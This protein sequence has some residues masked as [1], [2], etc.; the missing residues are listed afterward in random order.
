MKKYLKIG[1]LLSERGVRVAIYLSCVFT[2]GG[3]LITFNS[4][5]VGALRFLCQVYHQFECVS[6]NFSRSKSIDMGDVRFVEGYP[7]TFA[8]KEIRGEGPGKIF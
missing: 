7:R 6:L 4:S 5:E 3:A 2:Q 8:D 1:H